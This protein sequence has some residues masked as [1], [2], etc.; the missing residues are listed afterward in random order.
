MLVLFC[1]F[2]KISKFAL[3]GVML[4]YEQTSIERKKGVSGRIQNEPWVVSDMSHFGC[5]SFWPIISVWVFSA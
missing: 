4:M 2:I 3:P 1:F 5:G